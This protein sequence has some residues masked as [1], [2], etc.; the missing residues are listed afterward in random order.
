[1]KKTRAN[2]KISANQQYIIKMNRGNQ[3]V[4]VN[5]ISNFLSLKSL[6]ETFEA[7]GDQKFIIQPYLEHNLEFRVFFIKNEIY[8]VIEKR[9]DNTDFRGNFRNSTGRVL[10][11]LDPHLKDLIYRAIQESKLDYG[12]IDIFLYQNQYYFLE[13]NAIP[14]FKQIEEISAKNIAKEIIL[15]LF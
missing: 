15:K 8:S 3:G 6:L 1:M 14:G 10:T 5:F 2:K 11:N 13:I 4:G 12:G 7:I 9:L